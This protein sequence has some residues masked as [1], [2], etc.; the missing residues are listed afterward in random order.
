MGKVIALREDTDLD[1]PWL[2]QC[3]VTNPGSGSEMG[4]G[5][6]AGD[7]KGKIKFPG[8]K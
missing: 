1:P 4:F 6:I 5:P 2:V 8:K 7:P 3:V